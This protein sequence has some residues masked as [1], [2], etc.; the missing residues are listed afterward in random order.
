MKVTL[1]SKPDKNLSAKVQILLNRGLTPKN[2]KNYF[3]STDEMINSP[4]SFGEDVM[5][6]RNV[7]V[8]D[9]DFHT[10]YNKHGKACNPPIPVTVEDHVWLTSNI[11]VQKGLGA[12]SLGN[13]E[14]YDYQGN[15]IKTIKNATSY[16]V[17]RDDN[18]KTLYD[19]NKAYDI[20]VID[21]KLHYITDAGKVAYKGAIYKTFDLET[22]KENIIGTI[23][24]STTQQ[25]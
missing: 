13:I 18:C 14:I 9:S 3:N 25:C 19:S 15:L 5:I 16:L 20:R 22:H 12:I 10:I 11:I 24:A 21:N 2:L 4:L 17:F 1:T 7:I 8:Y 23:N 6:G